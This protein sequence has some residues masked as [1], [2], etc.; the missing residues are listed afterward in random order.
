MIVVVTGSRNWLYPV[1]VG[2]RL[3][4]LYVK[5]GPFTLYHGDCR[6][7]DGNPIGADKHANDWAERT[8]GIIIRRFP[9][10]WKLYG[11]SAGPRRN[12]KMI[13][14]ARQNV[15][16]L[17]DVCCEAFQRNKSQGTQTTIDIA[18]DYH[19]PLKKWT[20]DDVKS[21]MKHPS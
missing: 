12:R 9:A 1:F 3:N 11:R 15:K 8:P 7:R 5:H 10:N 17:D 16:T 20:E 21:L 14:E 18:K 6:D 4:S 2:L 13:Q 19:I